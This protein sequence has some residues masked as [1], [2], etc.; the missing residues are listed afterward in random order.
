MRANLIYLGLPRYSSEATTFLSHRAIV[1]RVS[2]Y[3]FA[4]LGSK[5]SWRSSSSFLENL[6]E[7]RHIGVAQIESDFLDGYA[8]FNEKRHRLF[9]ALLYTVLSRG[10]VLV[11]AKFLTE[12]FVGK[13]Q[14]VRN[15]FKFQLFFETVA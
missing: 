6:G 8:V 9:Y 14:F 5:C 15:R 1:L 2:L 11:R 12:G 7:V 3:A 4:M 13:P 10:D